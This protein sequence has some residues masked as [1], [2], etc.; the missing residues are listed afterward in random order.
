VGSG[1]LWLCLL[2]SVPTSSAVSEGRPSCSYSI[3]LAKLAFVAFVT[4][5]AEDQLALLPE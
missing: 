3:S 1:L 5:L 4:L 2:R